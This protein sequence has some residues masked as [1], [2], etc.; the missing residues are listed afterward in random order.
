VKI[1]TFYGAV[2]EL[3][4]PFHHLVSHLSSTLKLDISKQLMSILMKNMANRLNPIFIRMKEDLKQ[5]TVKV[6]HA[7]ETTLVISKQ[8]ETQKNRK[9]SYVY[10]YTTSFYDELIR[11]MVDTDI[12]V[13]QRFYIHWAMIS[14][15]SVWNAYGKKTA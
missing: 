5:N 3:G 11:I 15:I 12:D 10:V 1:G 2:Y 9:L 7:D 6:I 14:I 4:I 8:P 13:L